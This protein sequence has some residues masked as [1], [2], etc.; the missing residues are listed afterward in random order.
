MATWNQDDLFI[1]S[2]VWQAQPEFSNSSV[3]IKVK[4]ANEAIEPAYFNQC[5][6]SAF[7]GD[8]DY[9]DHDVVSGTVTF[10]L[11][12]L[13]DESEKEEYLEKKASLLLDELAKHKDWGKEGGPNLR[14]GYDLLD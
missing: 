14:T 9:V 13:L 10:T 11:S 1:L 7:V 6:E 2:I 8:R 4:F 12:A 5:V 3:T